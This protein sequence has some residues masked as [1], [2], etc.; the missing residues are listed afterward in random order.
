MLYSLCFLLGVEHRP[1]IASNGKNE[2]VKENVPLQDYT[3]F[4]I[5]GNAR[6][7]TEVKDKKELMQAVQWAKEKNLPFFVLGG[8]SNLLVSDNGFD[9]LVIK[10][11]D[12]RLEID[13]LHEKETIAK[14]GAGVRLQKLNAMT[15]QHSFTG[16]EWSAG[17]PMAT[18]G[19]AVRMNAG[20][21]NDYTADI[22]EKV[23][24][25]DAKTMEIKTFSKQD[26]AFDY[27][28]SIFSENP[29][30]IVLQV[31]LK[32]KKGVKEEIEQRIKKFLRRRQ[33]GH[34]KNFS[35]GSVFKNLPDVSAGELIE[36]CGLKGK[37]IGDA[38]ISELHANFIVNLD[39][40]SSDDVLKLIKLAKEQVKEK[41]DVQLEEEIQ[42]LG[43]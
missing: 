8:G 32:L 43:F 9:G 28:K 40:A 4:R 19:G 15:T 6:H 29:N 14:A 36:K 30:L 41:L 39:N 21:F 35:A 7:F 2:M 10:M 37:R 5:G 25:L 18:I 12:E 23:E 13:G 20:A 42:F 1:E 34:P 22:V 17:I 31:W 26:C 11:K 24:A 33:Q 16:L 3:T 38:E 27:K